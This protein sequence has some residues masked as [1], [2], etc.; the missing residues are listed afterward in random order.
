MSWH[1]SWWGGVFVGLLHCSN[2]AEPTQRTRGALE[3]VNYALI[4][5]AK[6]EEHL[7]SVRGEPKHQLA[8]QQAQQLRNEAPHNDI[9][10]QVLTEFHAPAIGQGRLG[11]SAEDRRLLIFTAYT[12]CDPLT[13]EVVSQHYIARHPELRL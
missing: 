11:N 7:R 13:R 10:L 9:P 3:E 1:R 5:C 6:L 12:L 2:D 4:D 8:L